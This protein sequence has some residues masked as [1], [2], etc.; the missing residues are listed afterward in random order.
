M[1]DSALS[2]LRIVDCS[3]AVAG[4]FCAKVFADLGADVIKVEPPQGDSSRRRGPFPNDK[5]HPECS[6]QFLYNNTNKRSVTLDL[7]HDDDRT[8]LR[9]LVSQADLL[10]IDLS[11]EKLDELGLGYEELCTDNDQLIVTCISPFGLEGPYRNYRGSELINFHI[12]GLGVETPHNQVTDPPREPPLK[13]GGYQASY[14]TGWTAAMASM[15]AL[16]HRRAQGRGQCVDIAAMESVASML[17][18][19]FAAQSYHPEVPP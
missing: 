10:I 17:R 15:V 13:A 3:Q 2:H 8:Q 1:T 4:P 6:G 12:G 7:E 19:S 11:P 16:Q 14:L 18:Y 9:R 5:P